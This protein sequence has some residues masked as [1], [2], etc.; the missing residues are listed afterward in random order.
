MINAR[1]NKHEYKEGIVIVSI[2][3]LF[4]ILDISRTKEKEENQLHKT[5]TRNV[6]FFRTRIIKRKRKRK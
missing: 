4:H 2:S 1:I 5:N 6:F 3:N